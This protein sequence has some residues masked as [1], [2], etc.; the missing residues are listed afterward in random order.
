MCALVELISMT[1]LSL[2][3]TEELSIVGMRPDVWV[4]MHSDGVVRRPVGVLEVKKP[5]AGA[6]A[7]PIVLGQILDYLRV[8]RHQFGVLDAFAIGTTF[9]EWRVFRLPADDNVHGGLRM[10]D[11]S[12]I[13]DG[14]GSAAAFCTSLT[15]A[16]LLMTKS[17]LLPVPT[18]N[19]S[20]LDPQRAYLKIDAKSWTWVSPSK[21]TPLDYLTTAKANSLLLLQDLGSGAHGHTWLAC[22]DAGKVVVVKIGRTVG[23]VLAPDVGGGVAA[24]ALLTAKQQLE[25]EL[26][27]WAAVNDHIPSPSM[28]TLAGRPAL[29]MPYVGPVVK[30]ECDEDVVKAVSKMAS[31]GFWHKD[32]HWRHVCR[33]P[34]DGSI[35]FIDFGA[36]DAITKAQRQDAFLAM[37]SSLSL[38][39]P[40][41][42]LVPQYR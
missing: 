18:S 41:E 1:G 7:H 5:G 28:I 23:S 29:R 12:P 40:P 22:S 3:C 38:E 31:Q 42:P 9:E 26:E 27:I 39:A 25:A 32:L 11:A 2:T 13:I 14:H 36:C 35:V 33:A 6:L 20:A 21:A 10:V 24:P 15:T 34:V 4:I 30:G 8:L 19:P 37:L 17:R 16:L